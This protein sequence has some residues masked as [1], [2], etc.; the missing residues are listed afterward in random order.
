MLPGTLTSVC[1]P[2]S[3]ATVGRGAVFQG[4]EVRAG[5][6]HVL[7]VEAVAD[8]LLVVAIP[9]DGIDRGAPA[10]HNAVP[11]GQDVRIPFTG[12]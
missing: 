1:F 10:E 6:R 7:K 3:T 4:R 12:V 8:L 9:A 2:L 11:A 5:Q